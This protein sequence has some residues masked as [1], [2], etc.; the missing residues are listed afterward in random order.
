LIYRNLENAQEQIAEG[1]AP[2]YSRLWLAKKQEGP[3]ALEVG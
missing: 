1:N 2:A 3:A